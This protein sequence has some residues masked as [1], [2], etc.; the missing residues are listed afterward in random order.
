MSTHVPT[1]PDVAPETDEATRVAR[2]IVRSRAVDEFV[3]GLGRRG[4][5][6]MVPPAR[7]IEGH[8]YGALAA[9]RP[10]DWTFG[11]GRMGAVALERGLPT[12]TWLAQILGSASASHLGHAMPAEGTASEVRCVSTSSLMG[13]HLAQAGGVAHAMGH[14]RSGE[15]ALAWFGPGAAA[16]GDAHVAFNF[17]GVFQ[18]PAIFY[19]CSSGDDAADRERLGGTSFADFAD[20]YGVPAVI[21][22]GGDPLAVRDAVAVAVER[23]RSGGGPTLIEGRTTTDPLLALDA[24]P[25]ALV[26]AWTQALQ[27][28]LRGLVEQLLAEGPP[29]LATLFEHVFAELTP[30]LREQRDQLQSHRARFASGEID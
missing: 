14:K 28:E 20:G 4:L 12:R 9:L 21:T 29:S 7:G 30:R 26:E 11:D 27:G 19:F 25:P 8:L 13:T 10:S 18:T 1:T 5:T 16:T 2:A 17:A 15:V 24:A 6:S 22:D 3:G 23:A